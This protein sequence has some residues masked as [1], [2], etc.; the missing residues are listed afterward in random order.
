MKEPLVYFNCIVQTFEHA[1]FQR[2]CPHH[3]DAL[4]TLQTLS[5]TENKTCMSS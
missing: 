4:Q 3:E 1:A 2:S 5:E